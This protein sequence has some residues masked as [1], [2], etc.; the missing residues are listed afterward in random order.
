MQVVLYDGNKMVV[1]QV[2]V[3]DMF[4]VYVLLCVVIVLHAAQSSNASGPPLVKFLCGADV[5]ESFAVPGIWRPE[6]VML[7]F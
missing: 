6:H 7:A 4:V 3:T 1:V 5:L 2:V